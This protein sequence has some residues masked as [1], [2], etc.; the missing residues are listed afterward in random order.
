MMELVP[1]RGAADVTDIH[2]TYLNGPDIG[3]LEMT[4]DEILD[5]VI[6]DDR[7]LALSGGGDEV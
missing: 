3:A 4:E 5:A 2:F 1:K 6:Q 7:F